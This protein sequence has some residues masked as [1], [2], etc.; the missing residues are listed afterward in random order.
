MGAAFGLMAG[1]GAKGATRP[2]ILFMFSDDHA[3]QAIGAYGSIVNKTPNIDRIAKEGVIFEHNV[4]GNSLCGP[5][6]ATVLT[7]KFSHLN[8]F[9]TN[10]DAFDGSQTTF[11]KLLQAAGYDTA[12]IG[13][14]HLVSDPTGFNHW[15]ILPAQGNYYNPEFI[16][17]Q[18]KRQIEGYVTDI[19]ADLSLDWL[20]KGRDPNKPFLLMCQHKAPHRNWSPGP[21]H[22]TMYDDVTLPEPPTLFDDYA[23]RAPVLA[24][25]EAMIAKHLSYDNDLKIPG[26]GIPDGYGADPK[27]EEYK[28]MTPEQKAQW[29]AAYAPLKEAFLKEKP[30][31]KDLVRWKYQRYMKDY[32]RCIASIDD[33]VG[34]MLDYLDA[35]GLAENTIVIYGSD[36]GFYLGEH[37]LFDKRWMYRESLAMPLVARWPGVAKPGTQVERLTQ[38]IDYAPTFLEAAG[39]AVPEDMQGQSLIP[40]MRGETPANW[41][42]AIYY[43]Y[44]ENGWHNVAPHEGVSTLKYKLIHYYGVD[45]WELFDLEKDPQE[46]NSVYDD[47]KYAET[48]A[49]MKK[50]LDELKKQ[51]AVP[52]SDSMPQPATS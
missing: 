46:M 22:L 21:K 34:R 2:N 29:D 25:N 23:H 11:P 35:K 14:W 10:E 20:D 38:N 48:V 33:N 47:P 39:V 12:L 31:G 19:I 50:R 40:L 30:E 36:Q 1:R 32:L 3:Q 17:T 8:G 37:G 13:K 43:H 44:Y 9:R 24:Q 7:G 4:C 26:L 45:Q 52:A 5:S 28:R 6:R 41:R 49:A 15:D 18:G 42:D 27:N 16:N 51:Y